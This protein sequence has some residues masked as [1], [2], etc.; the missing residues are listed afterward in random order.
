MTEFFPVSFSQSLII[1]KYDKINIDLERNRLLVNGLEVKYKKRGN[2]GMKLIINKEGVLIDSFF[3]DLED[4]ELGDLGNDLG[5]N[6]EKREEKVFFFTIDEKNRKISLHENI[7]DLIFDIVNES[8]GGR[9]V[10][11]NLYKVKTNFYTESLEGYFLFTEKSLSLASNRTQVTNVYDIADGETIHKY[12]WKA[13]MFHFEEE[14]DSLYLHD[15]IPTFE[16]F[17]SIFTKIE[18][19]RLMICLRENIEKIINI[20]KDY[21]RTIPRNEI[22]NIFFMPQITGFFDQISKITNEK[23]LYPHIYEFVSFNSYQPLVQFICRSNSGISST[24]IFPY[25]PYLIKNFLTIYPNFKGKEH[26]EA[27]KTEIE[28][29]VDIMLMREEFQEDEE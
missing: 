23:E 25:L 6:L 22:E 24:I 27:L 18:E 26:I 3:K 15:V 14:G 10:F 29:T 28:R 11:D 7:K 1:T 5:N 16:Y 4:S 19:Y 12:F 21:M 20:T 17:K 8:G 13:V 2:D 9:Y